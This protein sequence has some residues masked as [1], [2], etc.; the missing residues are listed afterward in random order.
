MKTLTIY[1]R[2]VLQRTGFRKHPYKKM[3]QFVIYY[4]GVEFMS[5]A[6]IRNSHEWI[7]L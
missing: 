4:G 1:K 3:G 6:K 7:E 5:K 2:E